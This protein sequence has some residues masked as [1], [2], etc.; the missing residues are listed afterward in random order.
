[1]FSQTLGVNMS[2]LKWLN[3]NE[4]T[5]EGM[6]L[7]LAKGDLI[8]NSVL[9]PIKRINGILYFNYWK[10]YLPIPQELNCKA[11]K[12]VRFLGPLPIP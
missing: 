6:Y 11:N 9:T 5:E 12:D 4:V 2:N 3:V 1:M 10:Q 8:G 7:A